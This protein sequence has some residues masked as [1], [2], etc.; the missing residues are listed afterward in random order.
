MYEYEELAPG[1]VYR[2]EADTVTVITWKDVPTNSWQACAAGDPEG[3]AAK[4]AT[5][6]Q[7]VA[8]A[9]HKAQADVIIYHNVNAFTRNHDAEPEYRQVFGF[10]DARAAT[11]DPHQYAEMCFALFNGAPSTEGHFLSE[12]YYAL[13]NRSLSVSDIVVVCGRVMRCDTVGFTELDELPPVASG[14]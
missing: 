5:R 10:N 3:T 4:G 2:H 9:L 8:R 12:A 6:D 7:A 14:R 11:T 13:R 1:L